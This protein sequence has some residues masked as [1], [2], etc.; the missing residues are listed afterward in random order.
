MEMEGD[1]PIYMKML[2]YLIDFIYFQWGKLRMS[3]HIVWFWPYTTVNSII[4]YIVIFGRLKNN[5]NDTKPS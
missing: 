2:S 1:G 5:N 4:S 3:F